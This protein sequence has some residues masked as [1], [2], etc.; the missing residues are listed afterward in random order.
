MMENTLETDVARRTQARILDAANQVIQKVGY[1]RL[2]MD[3]VAKGSGI[4]RQTIY[5]YFPNKAQLAVAVLLRE[6]ALVNERAKQSLSDDLEGL[7][8]LCAAIMA[9]VDAARATPIFEGMFEEGSVGYVNELAEHSQVITRMMHDYWS[10][11][12]ERLA[13]TGQVRTDVPI[14]RL[15]WWLSFVYRAL[16]SRP[17]EDLD[18]SEDMQALIR[19]F[20][21]P[22]V[23]VV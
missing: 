11:V 6:G 1:T 17:T 8:L 13:A 10:P 22:S 12:I 20:V 15:E 3:A 14:E 4:T 2:R 7:D 19:Q 21:A 5:N 16:L 18:N 23:M 9:L